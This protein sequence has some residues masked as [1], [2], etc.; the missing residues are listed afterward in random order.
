MSIH[1]SLN[2]FPL[3]CTR[4]ILQSFIEPYNFFQQNQNDDFVYHYFLVRTV[5]QTW[6][7]IVTVVVPPPPLEC[8]KYFASTGN[9]AVLEWFK[10]DLLKEMLTK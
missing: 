4:L 7:R 1:P 2:N 8:I 3:D 5:C 9:I 6:Y 10:Y